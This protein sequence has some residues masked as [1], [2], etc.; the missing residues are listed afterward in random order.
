VKPP[1]S[2]IF[3]CVSPAPEKKG[4]RL[5]RMTVGKDRWPVWPVVVAGVERLAGAVEGEQQQDWTEEWK[6]A[7][8][9]RA[10]I[11]LILV[12]KTTRYCMWSSLQTR[13]A[14]CP[15]PWKDIEFGGQRGISGNVQW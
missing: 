11:R 8:G 13:W 4:A 1:K 7:M 15:P 5:R 10:R 14:L 2:V 3:V 9:G 6:E 12:R